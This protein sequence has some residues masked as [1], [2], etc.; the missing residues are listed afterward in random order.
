MTTVEYWKYNFGRKPFGNCKVCNNSIRVSTDISR[1]LRINNYN[2]IK[3]PQVQWLNEIPLCYQCIKLGNTI[4][5][6]QLN[7][8]K[9]K[10]EEQSFT[11]KPRDN[12]VAN[13]YIMNG[14]CYHGSNKYKLCGDKNIYSESLCEKHYNLLY[15]GRVFKKGKFVR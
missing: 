6:I 12:Y 15:E 7:Y 4:D 9:N 14:Y 13:W 11:F 2:N 8:E 5:E 3:Y 1:Y 10:N